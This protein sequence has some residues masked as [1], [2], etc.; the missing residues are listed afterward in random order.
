MFHSG[1]NNVNRIE[2]ER[3]C[4][5]YGGYR[6]VTILERLPG[7]KV[8]EVIDLYEHFGEREANKLW[9]Q[10]SAI[11]TQAAKG[12]VQSFHH[13]ADPN[14]ILIKHELPDL[15]INGQVT[16]INNIPIEQL[17]ARW[18]EQPN[19]IS[20]SAVV[21]QQTNTVRLIGWD[22]QNNFHKQKSG[23]PTEPNLSDP[24]RNL[25]QQSRAFEVELSNGQKRVI[26][27]EGLKPHQGLEDIDFD[28]Q[29]IEELNR[30][31]PDEPYKIKVG[32]KEEINRVQQEEQR[33]RLKY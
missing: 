30:Q 20:A 22:D 25:A 29:A 14:R 17:K 23:E 7:G 9:G 26:E 16:H 31:K 6:D 24:R 28:H 15:I 13:Q 19:Q 5:E 2:A 10:S 12:P 32:E 1:W 8:F 21:L 27:V 11:F 3:F 4:D 33:Q 18:D